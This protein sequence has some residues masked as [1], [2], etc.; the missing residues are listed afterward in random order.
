[1]RLVVIAVIAMLAVAFCRVLHAS[2][3]SDNMNGGGCFVDSTGQV[4]STLVR[5]LKS[6]EGDL[7]TVETLDGRKLRGRLS[8]TDKGISVLQKDNSSLSKTVSVKEDVRWADLYKLKNN[9]DMKGNNLNILGIAG[10][11]ILTLAAILLIPL[12]N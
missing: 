11:A 3:Q 2:E 5:I 8:L 7:F 10:G 4:D 12:L 1:M 6:M 9:S